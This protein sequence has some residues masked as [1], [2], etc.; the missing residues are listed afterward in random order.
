ML[1]AFFIFLAIPDKFTTL[2]N[3]ES[4][5]VIEETVLLSF[6]LWTLKLE[7][8]VYVAGALPLGPNTAT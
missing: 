5:E 6:R 2:K 4:E 7:T 3:K 8:L 1:F